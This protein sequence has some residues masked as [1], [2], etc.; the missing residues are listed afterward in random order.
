M[1]KLNLSNVKTITTLEKRLLKEMG[2]QDFGDID[3]GIY[4]ILEDADMEQIKSIVTKLN[5]SSKFFNKA[6]T[7]AHDYN[8]DLDIEN[9]EDLQEIKYYLFMD[10]MEYKFDNR[11]LTFTQFLKNNLS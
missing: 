8:E 4:E 11:K 10:Y 1:E 7:Y 6:E 2:N 3:F 9:F 5:I